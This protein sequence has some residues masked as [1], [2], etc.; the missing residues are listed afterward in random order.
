[1]ENRISLSAVVL[2]VVMIFLLET[3]SLREADAPRSEN[4]EFLTVLSSGDTDWVESNPFREMV[5]HTYFNLHNAHDIERMPSSS[6]SSDPG[7]HAG[8]GVD[9]TE[10]PI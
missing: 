4:A 7:T 9:H 10:R 8:P 6:L 1:M 3:S 5:R 2:L